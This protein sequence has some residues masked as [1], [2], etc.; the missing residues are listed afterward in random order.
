MTSWNWVW[1][2]FTKCKNQ[3]LKYKKAELVLKE[4]VCFHL[5]SVKV[6]TFFTSHCH[7][8]RSW[9]SSFLILFSAGLVR[10]IEDNAVS[11]PVPWLKP[12]L[13]NAPPNWMKTFT[14][15]YGAHV[16]EGLFHSTSYDDDDSSP[17]GS[18]HCVLPPHLSTT[19]SRVYVKKANKTTARFAV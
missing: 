11:S 14:H 9:N 19:F 12:P 17:F 3:I 6:H 4:A 15:T 5:L 18:V 1:T 8:V 13:P 7:R 10:T 16:S 2:L